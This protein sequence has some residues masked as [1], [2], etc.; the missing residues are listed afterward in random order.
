[1]KASAKGTSRAV[2]AALWLVP[3]MLGGCIPSNVVAKQDRMVEAP[4]TELQ[5]VPGDAAQLGGFYESVQITGDAAVS[6]RKVFYW[7]DEGGKYTAAALIDGPDGVEFQ[8][9]V[10]TWRATAEGLVLDDADAVP[11]AVAGEHVRLATGGG[12]LTL[13]RSILQ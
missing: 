10:G 2:V 6:L 1:M 13:R 9:L 4:L 12:G 7:F 8:T 5:F 3:T 11:V